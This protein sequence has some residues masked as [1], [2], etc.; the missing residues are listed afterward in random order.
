MYYAAG[1]KHDAE[2]V[3]RQTELLLSVQQRTLLAPM[4]AQSQILFQED[5][6]MRPSRQ[7]SQTRAS[8]EIDDMF[9]GLDRRGLHPLEQN[10]CASM[11]ELQTRFGQEAVALRPERDGVAPRAAPFQ[12]FTYLSEP[13]YL[14]R[15]RE[16]DRQPDF[17][18]H[19]PLEHALPDEPTAAALR[20]VRRS[21]CL[22]PSAR[23]A[24][25]PP[26]VRTGAPPAMS[27]LLEA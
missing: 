13:A 1:R 6:S 8:I 3:Q 25:V 4:L 11:S 23:G 15:D 22:D 20:Q 9:R 24:R 5:H 21:D 16:T 7:W 18:R 19:D 10:R 12:H 27:F 14:L 26:A 2:A 17:L